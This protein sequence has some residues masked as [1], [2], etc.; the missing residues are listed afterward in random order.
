M[1]AVPLPKCLF[2]I[3]FIK[4]RSDF[5]LQISIFLINKT[6]LIFLDKITFFKLY[7]KIDLIFF[8]KKSCSFLY[9]KNRFDFLYKTYLFYLHKN[10]YDFS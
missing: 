7:T 4:K 2:L 1:N 8:N 6:D 3:L 10:R 5:S 9:I